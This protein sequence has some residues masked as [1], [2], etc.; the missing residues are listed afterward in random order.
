MSY[1]LKQV[2]DHNKQIAY[3]LEEYNTTHSE[4]IKMGGE[5][6]LNYKQKS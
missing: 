1:L 6:I 5:A 4:Y 2:R 3:Y